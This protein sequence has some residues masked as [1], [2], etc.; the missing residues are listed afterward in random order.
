MPKSIIDIVIWDVLSRSGAI[1]TL[2]SVYYNP[3]GRQDEIVSGSKRITKLR[4]LEDLI[5]AGLIICKRESMGRPIV[6]YELTEEGKR[7][8]KHLEQIKEGDRNDPMD[9]GAPSEGGI[10]NDQGDNIE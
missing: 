2:M 7:I 6:R 4:R 3:G 5:E 9:C 8:C 1:E 10:V